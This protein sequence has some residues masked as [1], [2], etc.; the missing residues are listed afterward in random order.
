MKN[1][2]NKW[3][4]L[5]DRAAWTA[6]QTSLGVVGA[7]AIDGHVDWKVVGI[8]CGIATAGAVTKVMAAQQWGDSG[9][10]DAVPGATVI[11]PAKKK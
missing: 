11:E 6:I 4:D 9:L 8:A 3:V 1:R 2:I 10:G 5:V 7:T